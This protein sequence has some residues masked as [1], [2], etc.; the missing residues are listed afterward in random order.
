MTRFRL[1]MAVLGTAAMFAGLVL[2][3]IM[4]FTF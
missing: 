4:V 2:L 1:F 3:T